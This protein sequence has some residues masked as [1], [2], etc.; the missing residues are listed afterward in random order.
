MADLTA[1]RLREILDY[2]H[3]TGVFTWLRASARRPVGS[4]AGTKWGRGYISILISPKKHSAH[5]LAW[6]FVHGRWPLSEL[7]HINRNPSDNRISNLREATRSL[8]NRNS[9][10][11][12]YYKRG[13]KFIAAIS[14]NGRPVYLG[15]FDNPDSARSAYLAARNRIAPELG[16]V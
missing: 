11:R 8:N 16:G 14:V 4:V 6:L 13:S 1:E 3:E 12:G 7:D 9:G 15:S 2:N 10:G 5:R